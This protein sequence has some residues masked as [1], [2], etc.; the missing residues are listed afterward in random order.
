MRY[1]IHMTLTDRAGKET[2]LYGIS[3]GTKKIEALSADEDAVTELV[4]LCNAMKLDPVQLNDVAEDFLYEQDH[5]LVK[6]KL[7]A[8][9]KR[10][11]DEGIPNSV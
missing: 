7:S 1:T 3:C 2:A 8:T 4:N 6:N 5:S 9:G 11:G 10:V